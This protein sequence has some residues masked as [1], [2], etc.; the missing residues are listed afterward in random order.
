MK[1]LDCYLEGWN[2]THFIIYFTFSRASPSLT[3]WNALP[4]VT[5]HW[6]SLASRTSK[7]GK[8]SQYQ[9]EGE[10]LADKFGV[11]SQQLTCLLTRHAQIPGSHTRQQPNKSRKPVCYPSSL[12]DST[13]EPLTGLRICRNRSNFEISCLCWY[14]GFSPLNIVF[15]LERHL[16]WHRGEEAPEEVGKHKWER[17]RKKLSLSQ[18][19]GDSWWWSC[20]FSNHLELC[21]ALWTLSPILEVMLTIPVL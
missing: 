1:S 14:R 2:F 15:H 21:F 10:K 18:P 13:H 9:V 19:K 7:S 20:Q 6:Y 5:A 8:L 4:A 11:S 17:Q 3:H 16:T 12:P